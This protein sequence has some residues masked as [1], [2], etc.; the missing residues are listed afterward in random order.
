MNYTLA[1]ELKKAGFPQP[2]FKFG[3]IW[4]PDNPTEAVILAGGYFGRNGATYEF[5]TWHHTFMEESSILLPHW[6][7]APT[8]EDIAPLLPGCTFETWDHQA[9]CKYQSEENPLRTFGDTFAEA[10]AKMWLILK[11]AQESDFDWL[12]TLNK[13]NP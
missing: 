7:F 12:I 1:H 10:A 11:E 2:E 5:N 8:L 9:S 4:M 13:K 6:A 3:Q